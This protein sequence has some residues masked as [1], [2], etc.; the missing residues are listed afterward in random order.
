M[1][2][3][4]T[5][6][7]WPFITINF[8][9]CNIC[10]IWEIAMICRSILNMFWPRRRPI[11]NGQTNENML[12]LCGAMF[13]LNDVNLGSSCHWCPDKVLKLAS[14]DPQ[15]RERNIWTIHKKTNCPN[16]WMICLYFSVAMVQL[17][18]L[19]PTS[20]PAVPVLAL[21][22]HA[23]RISQDIHRT[24]WVDKHHT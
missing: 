23:A 20:A 17:K 10:K 8:K 6:P 18:P 24:A 15:K 12:I 4:S 7:P 3:K 22:L 11:K 14:C 2:T 16:T 9:W 13:G 1:G 19:E 21:D 5:W